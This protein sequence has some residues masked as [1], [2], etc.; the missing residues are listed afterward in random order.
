MQRRAHDTLPM[1]EAVV[2]F[3]HDSRGIDANAIHFDG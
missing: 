3:R 1:F 2:G